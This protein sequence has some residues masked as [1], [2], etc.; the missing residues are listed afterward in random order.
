MGLQEFSKRKILDA[1]A[2]VAIKPMEIRTDREGFVKFTIQSVNGGVVVGPKL[3]IYD[4]RPTVIGT[5]QM[6]HSLWI[7]ELERA[8]NTPARAVVM[9][10]ASEVDR[11]QFFYINLYPAKDPPSALLSQHSYV[12][13]HNAGYKFRLADP[14]WIWQSQSNSRTGR[15]HEFILVAITGKDHRVVIESSG[16]ANI[17]H[18][19][20]GITIV[21]LDRQQISI[22]EYALEAH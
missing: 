2:N 15:H 5:A 8:V 7:E 16:Y 12:S 10:K 1:V 11:K 9:E 21:G 19:D 22:D 20:K 3:F 6:S 13:K 14:L 4:H 17:G 18:T